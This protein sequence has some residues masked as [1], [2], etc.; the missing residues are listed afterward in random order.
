MKVIS[1]G[2]KV[3]IQTGQFKNLKQT[4]CKFEGQYDLEG[5]VQCHNVFEIIQD[6]QIINTQF[7]L[8]VSK[9]VQSCHIHKE[10]HNIFKFQGKFDHESHGHVYQFSKHLRHI[11]NQ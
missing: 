8:E 10:S 6:L 7:K 2:V 4:F 3:I 9:T 5:Q 1:S 11:N